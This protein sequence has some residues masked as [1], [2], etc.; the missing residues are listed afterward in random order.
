MLNQQKEVLRL[1]WM[2]VLSL[3]INPEGHQVAINRWREM[4]GIQ[5]LGHGGT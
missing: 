2:L 1:Y 3:S 5:R 4:L